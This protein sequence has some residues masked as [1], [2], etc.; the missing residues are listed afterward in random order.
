M[1]LCLLHV[2]TCVIES[3]HA[4]MRKVGRLVGRLVSRSLMSCIARMDQLPHAKIPWAGALDLL[5]GIGN[6]LPPSLDPSSSRGFP[7]QPQI[8]IA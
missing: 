1:A 7:V 8:T 2:R 5:I 4:S 6:D 3:K